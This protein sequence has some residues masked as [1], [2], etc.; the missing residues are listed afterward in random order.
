MAELATYVGIE[1]RSVNVGATAV[2]RGVRVTRAADGTVAVEG[3][4]ARGDY[5]TL[6]DGEANQPVAVAAMGGG[7]KVAALASA[8]AVVG[9][10]AYA[11]ASGQFA[12]S[13]TVVV[14]R[15]TQPASG[16]GVLTEVELNIPA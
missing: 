6:T 2:A 8:V 4:A 3:A 12:A 13:G 10:L 9:G 16:A 5:V 7:G 1:P 11:A 14:G 15:F